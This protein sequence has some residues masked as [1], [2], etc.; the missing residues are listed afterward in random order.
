[1]SAPG[2]FVVGTDTGVGKTIIAA[3]LIYHLRDKGVNVGTF[4]PV[5]SGGR[6]DSTALLEASGADYP[7][8]LVNPYS[9]KFPISPHQAAQEESREIDV[10]VILEAF[11][12]LKE[13][14]NFI[15]AEGAGGLLVPLAPKYLIADLISELDLPVLVVARAA[16]GTI[17]HTLLTVKHAQSLGLEVAGIV[18]NNE[19]PV[20]ES[21]SVSRPEDL[22]H[23]TDVPLLGKFPHIDNLDAKT[24]KTALQKNLNLSLLPLPQE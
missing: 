20:A 19:K 10:K 5:E 14:H 22:S 18:I 3:A 7:I 2:L 4:K 8:E 15:I 13:R 21:E 24:L 17:N 12:K 6:E 23:Y 9:F 1:M 16:V 11:D